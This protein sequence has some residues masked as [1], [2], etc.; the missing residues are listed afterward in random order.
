MYKPSQYNKFF[1]ED[2]S[3]FLFN[4]FS[5]ACIKVKKAELE[6]IKS[7]LEKKKPC[8]GRYKKY[9]DILIKNG[10][11]IS[12]DIDEIKLL[13]YLYN[14]NYFSTDNITV[15]LVPTFQCNFKC[16]Y[17]FEAGYRENI[18]EAKDYF[19]ILRKFADKNFTHKRRV[20]ISL[21]GGEPLLKREEIFSYLNYL[22]VQSKKYNYKLS[23]NIVTNGFLLNKDVIKKLVKYNCTSIQVTLD[24]NKETHN[25]L[26]LLHNNGKTFDRI[27]ANLKTAIQYAINLKANVQFI[28]RINLLNQTTNDIKPIFNLFNKEERK[29]INIYFRPIYATSNFKVHNSNTISDLGKFYSEANKHGYKIAK[30]S[31]YLQY[32][33][34]DGGM[35][36]FYII[37]DLTI[38]KCINE[39][40]ETAKIGQIDKEGNIKQLN[41]M[42]MAEWYQKSNPFNDEKCRKCYY[43]PMCYGGCPLYYIKTGKRRCISKDIAVTPYFYS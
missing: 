3:L 39:P 10:F 42:H 25:R 40:T 37:P 27:V 21:F 20:H 17:C 19:N 28:L 7:I 2:G 8:K 11:I 4:S 41:L 1:W 35:N 23:T 36:F 9:Q 5:R 18:K 32:C 34:S 38:W 30:S 31:Y 22:S 13:E 26:R 43:L 33:E 29:K 16:P 14:A 24:G 6:K 15:A 12:S